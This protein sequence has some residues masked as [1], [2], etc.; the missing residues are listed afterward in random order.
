MRSE[1]DALGFAAGERG[2]GLAEA[3]VSQSHF[4]EDVELVDNFGEAGEVGERFLDRHVEDVV[5]VAALVLDVED[6]IFVTSSVAFF[7]GKFDVGEELHLD[8]NGAIAFAD[9]AAA[10][11]DVEGE[12][13]GGEALALGVGL[14]GEEGADFVEGLDVGDG[15]GARGA[16]DG[17]LVDE[18]NVVE[19]LRAGE[20]AEEVRGLGLACAGLAVERLHERAVE[21]LVDQRGF[22][23]AADAGDAAEEVERDFDVDAAEVVDARAGEAKDFAAGLAAVVRD[24]DGEPAGEVFAGNGARVGGDFGDRAGG[25][26]LATEFAGARAEVEQVVGGAND[27]GVVLDDEDGVAKVTQRVQDADQLGRIA[28]V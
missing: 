1:L 18:D 4:V 23:G 2:G 6:G 17:R 9:V 5:D 26:E 15:V 10:A 24:G 21:D 19:V 25:E 14:G 20:G 11:G 13:A 22:A 7:A 12:A 3:D 8:S 16:A 27:V 28:R